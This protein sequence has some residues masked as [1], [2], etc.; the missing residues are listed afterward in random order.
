MYDDFVRRSPTIAAIGLARALLH[1]S[2][3]RLKILLHRSLN[4]SPSSRMQRH[5]LGSLL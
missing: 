2:D 1:H 3:I 5:G 4:R